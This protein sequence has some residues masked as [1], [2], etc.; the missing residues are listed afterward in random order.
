MICDA[1]DDRRLQRFESARS[2]AE[3]V[4]STLEVPTKKPTDFSWQIVG[5]SKRTRTADFAVRGR[6]L[7]RL[8]IEAR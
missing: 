6:R 1:V 7:N 5:T 2:G 8:T 4:R 3:D